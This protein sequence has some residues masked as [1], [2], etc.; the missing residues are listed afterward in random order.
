VPRPP[1]GPDPGRPTGG[2]RT[3]SI[4][5]TRL[6][7]HQFYLV[8]ARNSNKHLMPFPPYEDEH[9]LLLLDES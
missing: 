4:A 5:C 2:S 1:N 7:P 9:D 8:L 6:A 3:P